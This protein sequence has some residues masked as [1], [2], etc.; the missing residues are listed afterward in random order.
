GDA[1]TAAALAVLLGERGLGGDDVDLTHR[2]DRLRRDRSTRAEDAR[3]LARR[4]AALAGD[5]SSGL[6]AGRHL[7][8]A[9][10]DRIA[11]QAGARGRYRLA[12][13]RGASLEAT[14]ALAN[15]RFLVVTDV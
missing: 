1:Q 9:Y 6:P 15:E 11:Q 5:G 12:N 14:D 4:W 10:P 8:R 7:A 13:G 2:L 3:S